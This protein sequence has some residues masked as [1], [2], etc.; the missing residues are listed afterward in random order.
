MIAP[1]GSLEFPLPANAPA[2]IGQVRMTTI[3]DFGGRV[4]RDVPVGR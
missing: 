4:A 2:A 1:G 3:N